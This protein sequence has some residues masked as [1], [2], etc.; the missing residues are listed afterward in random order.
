MKQLVRF[1]TLCLLALICIQPGRSH[2]ADTDGIPANGLNGP[3]TVVL[4]NGQFYQGRPIALRDGQ[5]IFIQSQAGGQAEYTFA[6]EEVERIDFPGNA[7]KA[8]AIRLVTTDNPQEALPILRMLLEQRGP[9]MAFVSESERSFFILLVQAEMECGDPYAALGL[10]RLL[11]ETTQDPAVTKQLEAIILEGYY[12]LG[13]I[14][15]TRQLA[16][17]WI[18]RHPRYGRSALG[19]YI[20]ARLDYDAGNYET[21][22]QTAL[23][24]VTFSSQYPMAFLAHAYAVAILS[25]VALDDMTEARALAVEMQARELD[26]PMSGGFETGAEQFRTL[27]APSNTPADSAPAPQDGFDAEA[28]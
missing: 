16:E 26:W 10:A 11:A 9:Y 6:P 12:R 22:F 24:P 21:A 17:E 28:E 4:R 7:Q 2:A 3:C 25:A 19:W 23:E 14:S 20:L 1:W 15:D 5:L 13:L 8:E 27:L 18:A